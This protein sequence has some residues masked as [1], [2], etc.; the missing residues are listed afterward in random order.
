MLLKLI[1][2]FVD[3]KFIRKR[4]RAMK[5]DLFWG[6]LIRFGIEIYLEVL[7]CVLITLTSLNKLEGGN[8]TKHLGIIYSVLMTAILFV[9][10]FTVSKLL[11]KN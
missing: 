2:C 10:P 8:T 1:S 6:G 11:Y 5:D 9:F 4:Y 7:I 3:S